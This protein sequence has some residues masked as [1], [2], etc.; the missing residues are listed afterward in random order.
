METGNREQ[1]EEDTI[2]QHGAMGPKVVLIEK[3]ITADKLIG[4]LIPDR[5]KTLL[6]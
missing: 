5:A 2:A 4:G 3:T 1:D 6:L